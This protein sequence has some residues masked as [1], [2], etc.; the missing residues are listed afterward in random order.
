[1]RMPMHAFHAPN[2]CSKKRKQTLR[3]SY[4]HNT[5]AAKY[6]TNSHK[7][8]YY[9]N[10]TRKLNLDK[11]YSTNNNNCMNHNNNNKKNTINP[12]NYIKNDE[13]KRKKKMKVKF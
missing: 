13:R 8:H 6:T 10:Q 1:M 12:L 5:S 3:I 11:N 9:L 7:N 2:T 4:N